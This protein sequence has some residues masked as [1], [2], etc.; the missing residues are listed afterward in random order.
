MTRIPLC[1]RVCAPFFT[2]HCSMYP[3][4]A[5]KKMELLTFVFFFSAFKQSILDPYRLFINQVEPTNW[6]S[7]VKEN[8]SCFLNQLKY[9]KD[10][11]SFPCGFKELL[12]DSMISGWKTMIFLPL[13]FH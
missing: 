11:F 12:E 2:S 10:F 3:L 9:P 5:Y 7:S 6:Q 1:T 4:L 13:Y 8:F